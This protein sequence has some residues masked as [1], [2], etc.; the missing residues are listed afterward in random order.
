MIS[1]GVDPRPAQHRLISRHNSVWS[2]LLSHEDRVCA[3]LRDEVLR[4]EKVLRPGGPEAV[5]SLLTRIARALDP[6]PR[7][8]S[9]AVV[10]ATSARSLCGRV[11][12]ISPSSRNAKSAR[13][14]G[15]PSLVNAL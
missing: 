9:C 4:S 15:A 10:V 13:I 12:E 5:V 8:T 2:A 7:D 11:R 3:R 1:I 14:V 6:R